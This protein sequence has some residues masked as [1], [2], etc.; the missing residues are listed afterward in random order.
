MA[1]AA[2]GGIVQLILAQGD[3]LTL[4]IN[5]TVVAAAIDQVALSV[6]RGVGKVKPE[7]VGGEDFVSMGDIQVFT[8]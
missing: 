6:R 8:P 1:A 5:Y 2:A 4:T 3:F 7:G